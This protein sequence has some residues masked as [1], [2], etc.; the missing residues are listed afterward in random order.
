MSTS[1]RWLDWEP[2]TRISAKSP[3][4][5]PTK[6]TKPEA[7]G[8]VGR[9]QN[10][11]GEGFVGFVGPCLGQ[12]P[13]IEGAADPAEL[14]RASGVLGQAAVRIVR[15]TIDPETGIWPIR[16]WG[17]ACGRGFVKNSRSAA[18]RKRKWRSLDD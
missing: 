10:L 1:S 12:I 13:K 14:S 15:H 3:K 6:P 2:T 8:F 17:A 4:R 9:L 7:E 16:E 5:A 11:K 18:N